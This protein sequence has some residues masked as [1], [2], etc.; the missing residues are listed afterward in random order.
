MHAGVESALQQIGRLKKI[1]EEGH[2]IITSVDGGPNG[3]NAIRNGYLDGIAAQQLITMGELSANIA[4]DAAEGK[5]AKETTIRLQSDLTT[6]E[7]VDSPDHW[8]NQLD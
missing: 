1:G 7:N 5:K 2:I 6:P 4:L 8:A 3:L